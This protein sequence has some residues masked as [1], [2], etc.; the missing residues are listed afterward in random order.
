MHP[1]SRFEDG[2]LILSME[3][4]EIP[5]KIDEYCDS[6]EHELFQRDPRLMNSQKL[7]TE[8]ADQQLSDKFHFLSK[9]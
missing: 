4:K 2:R 3:L 9:L 6:V 8:I 7:S 1:V 5:L